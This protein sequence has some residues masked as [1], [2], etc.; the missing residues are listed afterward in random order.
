MSQM[1]IMITGCTGNQ[2]GALSGALLEKGHAVRGLTRKPDS[3]KARKLADLGVEIVKG[4]FD[5]PASLRKS[6]SGMD[7][8]FAMGTPYEAGPDVETRQG[9]A[10]ADAAKAEGIAHLLYNSVSDADRDTGIPHFDSKRKVEKYIQSLEIPYTFICPVYFFDNIL[11]PFVLPSL[12]KGA[13]AMSLPPDRA[14]QGA[15]VSDIASFDAMVLERRE[16]FLGKRIN[17]ASDELTLSDYAQAIAEAS[18]KEIRYTRLSREQLSSF[19]E[20]WAKME[21]WFD[22]VGYS[23]DIEM[24]RRDYPEVGWHRFAEWTETRDWTVLA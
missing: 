19:G 22:R 18:G 8:L 23:A 17:I 20:D 4:D 11:S 24:L 5:D 13:L 2:G 6:I 16:E 21:L 10:L 14:L 7:A 15:A 1:K 9:Y 12:K 3:E